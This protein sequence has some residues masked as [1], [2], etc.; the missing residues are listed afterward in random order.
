M[1]KAIVVERA[2]AP[3]VLKLREVPLARPKRGE[4]LVRHAAIGVNFIDIYERTGLYKMAMP[5][6]PGREGA[7]TVAAVGPGVRNVKIGD[8][9][10][11]VDYDLGAYAES[12]IIS[13]D[14]LV[15]LPRGIS[16]ELAA[17]TIF[18]G[19]TA[20]FLVRRT[21]RIRP[22]D[23]VLIHAAAGGVGLIL[24]QWAKQLG[25]TVIATVGTPAKARLLKRLGI[26]HVIVYTREDFVARVRKI[27]KGRGVDVV[28]DSV[29]KDTFPGS[30]DCLR[31][32]GLFVTFGNASG[33]VP[34]FAPL[35]LAQK[36]SLFMTRPMLFQHIRD[37][38]DLRQGARELF[39]AIR[40]G[41]IMV[42]GGRV[43]RLK[44]ADKAHRD[45]AGRKTIGPSILVP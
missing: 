26:D 22:G 39:G 40:S 32:R 2:G 9:V 37:P 41:A 5:Y 7:G 17:A 18:K 43:Y 33:P 21:H 44:D 11:Y 20:W 14:K 25:A 13:A 38:K 30:L 3:S 19:L 24:S 45:L 29:G 31:P 15:R 42:E 8:S 27:T 16:P 1:T 6:T 12:R 23:M 36:G 10:A 34:P 4:A 35:L 28:Y